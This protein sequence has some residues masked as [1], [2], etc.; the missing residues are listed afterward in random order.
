MFSLVLLL[1]LLLSLASTELLT[2]STL[3]QQSVKVHLL[4][5]AGL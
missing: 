2:L 3:T 1:S 5:S 4:L